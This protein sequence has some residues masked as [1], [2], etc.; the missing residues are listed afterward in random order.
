MRLMRLRKKN[1]KKKK[2]EKLF[3]LHR[4]LRGRQK[5]LNGF[6]SVTFSIKRQGQGKGHTLVCAA[7]VAKASDCK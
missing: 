4:L 1:R 5:L 6:E 3:D 2:N 7:V